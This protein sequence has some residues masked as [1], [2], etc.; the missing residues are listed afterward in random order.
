MNLKLLKFTL[1]IPL[2]VACQAGSEILSPDGDDM[3]GISDFSITLSAESLTF[4]HAYDYAPSSM[5]VAIGEET[6]IVDLTR[7]PWMEVE[8]DVTVILP[9]TEVVLNFVPREPNYDADVRSGVICFKGKYTGKSKEVNVTQAGS[10]QDVRDTLDDVILTLEH[11]VNSD[12]VRNDDGT[13]AG[14][15]PGDAVLLRVPVKSLATGTDV[16]AM[17]NIGHQAG[18]SKS[19]WAAEYWD[20]GG[21]KLVRKFS[22]CC[23][24]DDF[25]HST[26]I[27]DFALTDQV[28]DDYVKFRLRLESGE[29]NTVYRIASSPWMGAAM[30]INSKYPA[31]T[32]YRKLLVLGDSFTYCWGGPFI[33]KQIARSQ[34]HR[35]DIRVHTEHD[36]SLAGHGNKYSLSDDAVNEGGYHVAFLQEK[37]GLHA[38]YADGKYA[39]ALTDANELA[40]AVWLESATCKVLIENTWAYAHDNY[41]GYGSYEAFDA[42]L[43]N[44]CDEIAASLRTEISPVGQA[45]AR[46]R[47]SHPD[48]SCIYTD[49]YNPSQD[50]A[51]LKSCVNYLKI[52]GGEFHD[53]PYNGEASAE[54]AAVLRQ[55]AYNVVN[56]APEE[57]P[58]ERVTFTFDFTSWPFSPDLPTGSTSSLKKDKDTYFFTHEDV[59]YPI[60]VYAPTSGYYYTGSALRFNSTGGGYITTPAVDGKALVEITVF[61]TNTTGSKKIYISSTGS[62]S[63]DVASFD[64]SSSGSK[65]TTKSLTGTLRNKSYY[66]Y[67]KANH[68]QI[69]KI[70][71][72]YE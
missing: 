51:Y 7:A 58:K 25:N 70:I 16:S 31:I 17:V 44:G 12:V 48:I 56:E 18:G 6:V 11:S 23:D 4:D 61:I 55:V 45:F 22:T 33:L 47:E 28:D 65:S 50:G 29:D 39:A 67:T 32:D 66:I 24:G 37:G 60:E 35:L 26:F 13:F 2:F 52:Y 40:K 19:R 14:M 10:Y 36:A 30:E 20:E 68:A 21:W 71:L 27:C 5:S 53:A 69:G 1:F 8:G 34:G 49:D 64:V 43:Q 46:V 59:D 15:R 63:C 3:G 62:D 41:M 54:N 57:K 38:E 72:I 42:R 9:N